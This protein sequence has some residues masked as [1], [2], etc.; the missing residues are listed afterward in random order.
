MKS[1][2]FEAEM[3]PKPNI[4]ISYSWLIVIGVI[5]TSNSKPLCG[6]QTVLTVVSA[7]EGARA[8]LGGEEG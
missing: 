5:E 8:A 7:A 1:K 3:N 2:S 4:V 6:E